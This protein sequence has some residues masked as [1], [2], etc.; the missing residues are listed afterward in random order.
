MKASIVSRISQ[1]RSKAM[2]AFL[3][4]AR[5]R[6]W[7]TRSVMSVTCRLTTSPSHKGDA[8]QMRSSSARSRSIGAS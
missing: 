8:R 2:G 5:Q 6:T 7:A 1:R 3:A 4:L